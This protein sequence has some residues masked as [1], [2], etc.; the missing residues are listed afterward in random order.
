MILIQ[1]THIIYNI[2]NLYLKLFLFILYMII[3]IPLGGIGKT[4]S[5]TRIHQTQSA[6]S[7]SGQTYTFLAF[8]FNK[9]IQNC[10]L[11][12]FIFHIPKSIRKYHL[13]DLISHH[14]PTLNAHCSELCKQTGGALETIA[15]C[16]STLKNRR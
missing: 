15:L 6:Y 3:L 9:K 4:F 16:L 11:R 8:R 5:R 1:I 13:Q 12:P 7:C 14:Y 10:L 2:Y